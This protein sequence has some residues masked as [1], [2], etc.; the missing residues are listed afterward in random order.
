MRKKLGF[1]SLALALVVTAGPASADEIVFHGL[2]VWY[3]PAG[4]ASVTVDIPA[5]F[6]C[7]G[8]S[9]PIAGKT[10][11][12]KGRPVVT[13]PAGALNPGDTVV[14]RVADGPFNGGLSTTTQLKIRALS[15]VSTQAFTITCPSGVTEAWATEVSL[16][17]PQPLG[18]IVIRRPVVGAPGGDFDASFGV[19]AKIQFVNTVSQA[20]TGFV[21]DNVTITTLNACWTHQPGPGAVVWPNPVT[22]DTDG[23]QVPD[24]ASPYGTSNF[25]PGWKWVNGS[26]V[27]CPVNHQGPHPKTCG[28]PGAACPE[29]PAPTPCTTEIASYLKER[30]TADGYIL[31]TAKVLNQK[32]SRRGKLTSDASAGTSTTIGTAERVTVTSADIGAERVQRCIQTGGT[33]S[34][35]N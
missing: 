23:N 26:L 30:Q 8:M 27:Q 21:F 17:G 5:G 22:I 25:F 4:G 15:L 28:A 10:I 18:T 32:F 7:G 9:G 6:F 34:G 16:N 14:D 19:A 31:D 12:L 29:D 33:V 35:S 13:N 3:T 20:R 24:Y 11:G 2:D 1:A